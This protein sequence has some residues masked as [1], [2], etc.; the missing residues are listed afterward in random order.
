MLKYLK[1]SET[2]VHRQMQFLD[3]YRVSIFCRERLNEDRFPLAADVQLRDV[4]SHVDGEPEVEPHFSVLEANAP[5]VRYYEESLRD[6]RP[7][8]VHAHFGH[9]ASRIAPASKAVGLPMITTF[10]GIDATQFLF[11]TTFKERYPHLLDSGPFF[12]AVSEFI[13]S[14]LVA[15]GVPAD[16]IVQHYIGVPVPE[17][18]SHV[19]EQ[20]TILQVSRLIKKKGVDRTIRA[21]AKVASKHNDLKL[22]LVGDGELREEL[23]ALSFDLGIGERV[24]FA[25]DC[26]YNQVREFY[27][28]ASFF[29][30]PSATTDIGDSEGLGISIQEAM[31]HELPVVATKVGGIPESVVEGT[32]VLVDEHDANGLAEAIDFY[33]SDLD[34][35]RRTGIAA[36]ARVRDVFDIATNTSALERIY[37]TALR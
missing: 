33:A 20:P 17:T 23:V 18:V 3:D 36:R 21:F 16:H 12:I 30:H 32:G 26:N 7:G 27:S 11:G 13:K 24:T 29:V 31:A 28:Q 10:H 9:H 2:F 14:Q 5:E 35:A 34:L 4:V 1:T 37:D 8:L 19:D 6:V 22:V 25:G 15:S